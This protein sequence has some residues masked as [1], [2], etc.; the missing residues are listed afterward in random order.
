[1]F[2]ILY[3]ICHPFVLTRR[4][5]GELFAGTLL[6]FLVTKVFRRTSKDPSPKLWARSKSFGLETDQQRKLLGPVMPEYDG[7][8]MTDDGWRTTGDGRRPTDDGPRT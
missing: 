4:C 8:R 3:V 5:S 2:D 7:R 1:M 6:G